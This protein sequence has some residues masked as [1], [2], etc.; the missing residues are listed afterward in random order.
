MRQMERCCARLSDLVVLDMVCIDSMINYWSHTEHF[1]RSSNVSADGIEP[2]AM[3]LRLH[4][5]SAMERG[6]ESSQMQEPEITPSAG[7]CGFLPIST[8]RMLIS[9]LDFACP[10]YMRDTLQRFDPDVIANHLG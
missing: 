7:L 5:D 8:C 4:V 9:I 1:P 6:S 2:G 10:E 3:L